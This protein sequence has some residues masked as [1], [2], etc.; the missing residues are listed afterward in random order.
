M[1]LT[2]KRKTVYALAKYLGTGVAMIE[3]HYGHLEL[4]RVAHEIAGKWGK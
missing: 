1:A 2:Y 4:T 3:Q